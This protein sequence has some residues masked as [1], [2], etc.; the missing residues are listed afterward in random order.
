MEIPSSIAS[1]E[2]LRR[3]YTNPKWNIICKIWR[4][5]RGGKTT[6]TTTILTTGFA[7]ILHCKYDNKPNSMMQIAHWNVQFIY[8]LVALHHRIAQLMAFYT[9]RFHISS[10]LL[11]KVHGKQCNNWQTISGFGATG[12]RSFAGI[13]LDVLWKQIRMGHI[14]Y[15]T[16]VFRRKI[17]IG[18]HRRISMTYFDFT[19][20][21]AGHP[22]WTS[23]RSIAFYCFWQR[24]FE[25]LDAINH[26]K[27]RENTQKLQ[28]NWWQFGQ[29]CTFVNSRKSK[30]INIC[31][32]VLNNFNF[33][34]CDL[35]CAKCT[36]KKMSMFHRTHRFDCH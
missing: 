6:T 26:H 11:I 31:G 9:P 2:L 5:R 25:P 21:V 19:S 3:I 14:F 27:N 17:T 7:A 34:V 30:S 33:I 8:L 23:G 10:V 1:T 28:K 4:R 15:L 13:P 24:P 16:T 35:Q 18:N 32:W 36:C 20:A 22:L 29:S 12:A